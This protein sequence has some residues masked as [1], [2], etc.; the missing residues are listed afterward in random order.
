MLAKNL[1]EVLFGKGSEINGFKI[2]DRR[3]VFNFPKVEE[4][5]VDRKVVVRAEDG[6][7]LYFVKRIEKLEE[8]L[9]KLENNKK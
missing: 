5:D 7:V 2:G 4:G 8:R 6:L 1:K 9:E 3:S